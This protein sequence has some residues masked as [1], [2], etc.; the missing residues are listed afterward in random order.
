MM[1]LTNV[2]SITDK[3]T[4]TRSIKLDNIRVNY[5]AIELEPRN[6]SRRDTGRRTL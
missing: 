5:G 6:R 1:T 2:L 4:G 3:G